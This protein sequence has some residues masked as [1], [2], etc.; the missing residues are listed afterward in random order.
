MVNKHRICRLSPLAKADLE[1]IWLYTFRQ[2]SQEQADGYNRI[3]MT[4][5]KGLASGN[6]VWQRADVREGY[7]KYK[8]GRHIIYF[9]CPNGYLD[10][11]R[12]LHE[13]MD[14]N[15]HLESQD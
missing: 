9:R 8:V 7:W 10:V 2:W 6:K 5:I 1:E 14:V 12:I 11:I 3:I 13:R 4:A 15:M